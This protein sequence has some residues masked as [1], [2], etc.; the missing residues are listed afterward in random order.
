[1]IQTAAAPAPH[2]WHHVKEWLEHAV[3][4]NMDALHVYFG[5]AILVVAALV[6]RRP[7]RSPL[8]WLV[9]LLLE[10]GN[11]YY[12]WTYEV[13]PGWE[14]KL[15]AAEGLRDIWNTMALPTFLLIACRWFPGLFTGW[16]KPGS[17]PDAGET[18]GEAG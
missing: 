9:L 18:G 12:D 7:L 4:L 11:E 16:R 14:R 6:L 10:L 17:A 3:G 2:D 13:W 5:L 1:L 8:P 15:Q